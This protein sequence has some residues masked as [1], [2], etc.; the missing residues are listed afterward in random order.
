MMNMAESI[1]ALGFSTRLKAALLKYVGFSANAHHT[2]DSLVVLYRQDPSAFEREFLRIPGAGSKSLN[3]LLDFFDRVGE[4]GNY[5]GRVIAIRADQALAGRK[6]ID[7]ACHYIDARSPLYSALRD[8]ERWLQ[9]GT[10]HIQ[11]P[12]DERSMFRSDRNG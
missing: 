8:V 5:A 10:V 9:A 12:G 11:Q 4:D 2:I 7:E 1:E 6:A 3:E